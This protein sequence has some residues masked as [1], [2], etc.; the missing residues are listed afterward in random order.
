MWHIGGWGRSAHQPRDCGIPF[1][2]DPVELAREDAGLR[3]AQTT[4][5]T[6]WTSAPQPEMQSDP[7]IRLNP[8]AACQEGA[9]VRLECRRQALWPT[10]GSAANT[11]AEKAYISA[12]IAARRHSC[13]SR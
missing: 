7:W 8:R 4:P 10:C 12:N 13:V 5:N 2:P 9:P 1:A 3:A 11:C 6:S